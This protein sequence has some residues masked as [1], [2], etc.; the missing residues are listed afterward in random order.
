MQLYNVLQYNICG[1][2]NC[3][4]IC[5][6][7]FKEPNILKIFEVYS[8][9][10]EQEVITDPLRT[11]SIFYTNTWSPGNFLQ[12]YIVTNGKH[13]LPNL[14]PLIVHYS[15]SE[16]RI[17]ISNIKCLHTILWLNVNRLHLIIM[18]PFGRK[19]C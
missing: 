4:S 15:S 16:G 12:C 18:F 1:K 8:Q 6:D 2:T 5:N 14:V 17:K 10:K 19:R 7:V 9:V 13:R 3:K 11:P